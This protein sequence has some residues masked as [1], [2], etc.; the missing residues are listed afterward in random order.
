MLSPIIIILGLLLLVKRLRKKKAR[1]DTSV[2][3]DC[4]GKPCAKCGGTAG[5]EPR[6][7]LVCYSFFI[8]TSK[9]PS[10]FRPICEKCKVIAGV[11]YT[12][13]TLLLG[14]WGLPYGPIYT[15]QALAKNNEGGIVLKKEDIELSE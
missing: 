6:A 5:V 2:I 8:V 1:E 3:L 4:K 7:Y 15:L 9:S 14:W 13:L 10:R 11:P 12:L